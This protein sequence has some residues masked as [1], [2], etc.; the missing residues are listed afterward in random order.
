MAR[1][2]VFQ[3]GKLMKL[4]LKSSLLGLVT[5]TL[6]SGLTARAQQGVPAAAKVIA[7]LEN[8][9]LKSQQTNNPDLAFPLLA[10]RFMYTSETGKL[11]DK[12]QYLADAKAIKY[13]S[14][15]Y[16]GMTIEV[17]GDTVIARGEARYTGS[18]SS[19]KSMDG[20]VRFTDT[21]VRMHQGKWECVASHVS[22]VSK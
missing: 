20:A 6:L 5:L 12:A 15:N 9:W 18:D 19:G 7:A 14:M 8:Q 1:L 13:A 4:S 3:R 10:S 11:M 17:F 16:A 21:W 22:N 2:A